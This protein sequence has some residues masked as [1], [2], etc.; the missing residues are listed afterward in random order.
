LYDDSA[1]GYISTVS[2]AALAEGYHFIIGT[3][4]GGGTG[5]NLNIYIDGSLVASTDADVTYTAMED[6]TASLFIG[7][8]TGTAAVDS[9]YSSYISNSFLEKSE[10]TS[11]DVWALWKLVQGV[12]GL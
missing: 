11:V 6:T 5:A 8:R 4:S 3:Y 12:Y 7:A 1:T 9:F 2:D 10:L